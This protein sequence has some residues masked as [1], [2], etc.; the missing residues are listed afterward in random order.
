MSDIIILNATPILKENEFNTLMQLVTPEKQERINRFHFYND[1][2]NT[3]L[4]DVLTRVEIC[5]LTGL[6]N[7]HHEFSVNEYGKPILSSNPRIH[8]NIS[9]S[10]NYVVCAIGD[11]QSGIDIEIIKP[12]DLKIANRFFAADEKEYIFNPKDSFITNRFY[13]IWT[14]KESR[15]KWE[16]KGLSIPLPSFSVLN[17]EE[18]KSI[19]YHMVINNDEAICHVCSYINDVPKI[20]EI[21]NAMLM[22]C[23]T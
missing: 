22:K 8:F 11:K 17:S 2:C 9:H 12:V 1:A 21:D 10:G 7:K 15:I 16:G 6:S 14:K 18:L 19:T 20:R 5:R 23:I 13:E 3:L 4:G